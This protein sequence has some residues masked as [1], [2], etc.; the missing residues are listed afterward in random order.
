MLISSIMADTT[1]P[2]TKTTMIL[3]LDDEEFAKH[4]LGEEEHGHS[5]NSWQYWKE[6]LMNDLMAVL[7]NHVLFGIV[8]ARDD[9][10]FTRWERFFNLLG[11]IGTQIMIISIIGTQDGVV[12][13]T[14]ACLR[15]MEEDVSCHETGNNTFSLPADGS[16]RDEW[17]PYIKTWA[18]TIDEAYASCP[19]DATLRECS[20]TKFCCYAHVGSILGEDKKDQWHGMSPSDPC[21]DYWFA[22]IVLASLYGVLLSYLILNPTVQC[23]L[24]RESKRWNPCAYFLIFIQCV[25]G[26]VWAVVYTEVSKELEISKAA[27]VSVLTNVAIGLFIT[28]VGVGLIMQSV[29][30]PAMER[31][32]CGCRGNHTEEGDPTASG[33]DGDGESGP[34]APHEI[35]S[36]PTTTVAGALAVGDSEGDDDESVSTVI[37]V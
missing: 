19:A 37:S 1:L 32:A 29:V 5:T 6:K 25:W 11:F 33:E 17:D 9:N 20:P 10:V 14:C 13:A 18:D 28:S 24:N 4:K 15:D 22:N 34:P 21:P 2:V 23:L 8:L 31:C 35:P 27:Y 16:L 12:N 3:D 30:N 36:K 7:R 26:V